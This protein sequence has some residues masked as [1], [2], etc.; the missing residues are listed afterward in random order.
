MTEKDKAMSYIDGFLLPLPRDKVDT[1]RGISEKAGKLWMEHGALA[2][3]ENVGD[4]LNIEGLASFNDYAGIKDGEVP[5]FSYIVYKSREHRDAVNKKVM[6][7]PRMNDMCKPEEMP[8]DVR[9]MAYGGFK[10]IVNM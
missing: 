9:R 3:V 2:Y 8:F 1:Y 7:D 5:V 6:A 10:S 4:D